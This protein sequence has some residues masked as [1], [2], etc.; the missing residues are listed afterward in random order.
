MSV[1]TRVAEIDWSTWRPAD[2]ATLVFVV[3]DDEVLLIRKL[4]GLGAGKINAPGGRLEPGE[5]HAACAVREAR[6]EVGIEPLD[7]AEAGE[8]FFQFLDGYSIQVRVFRAG[9]CAG[10]PRST[11]EA[12][13]AWTPLAAIP[14]AEMWADDAIWLPELLAGRSFRGRFVFDGERMLDY[15]MES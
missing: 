1:P 2:H 13:P 15:R 4:R 11:D 3:R 8:L 7:L 12:I 14:F 10:E 6:E 5:T 9:G